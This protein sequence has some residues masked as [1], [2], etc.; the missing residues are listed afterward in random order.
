MNEFWN[1]TGFVDLG[2]RSRHAQAFPAGLVRDGELVHEAVAAEAGSRWYLR[3][4]WGS[5]P[6]AVR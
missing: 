6:T 1:G 3:Q 5:Q 4:R 2:E